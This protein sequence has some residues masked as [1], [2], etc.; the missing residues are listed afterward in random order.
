M[1]ETIVSPGSRFSQ[2]DLENQSTT[3]I[4]TL[5]PCDLGRSVMKAIARWDHGLAGIGHSMSY[6]TGRVQGT[7]NMAQVEH[8]ATST[9]SGG[10]C[11]YAV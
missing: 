6:P 1:Q 5:L 3:T 11:K 8:D 9:Y 7:F 4:K 10:V 2:R